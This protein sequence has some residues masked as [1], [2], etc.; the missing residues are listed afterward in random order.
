LLA[1]VLADG[2]LKSRNG[3][4]RPDFHSLLVFQ[5]TFVKEHPRWKRQ[6]P[7][8]PTLGRNRYD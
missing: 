3:D 5:I 1:Q 2:G 8:Y 6:R 4:A 7:V